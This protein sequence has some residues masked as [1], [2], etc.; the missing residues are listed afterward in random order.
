MAGYIGSKASVVSSGAERKKTFSITDTTTSLTGLSY[1]V[2]QVHVFH[3]GVRLVD[4]TDYTATDGS[5]ITLTNAAENGDEVVVI[6][7]ATFQTSDTVSASQGG[8]FNDDIEINGDLTVDTNTLYVDSTNNQVGIGTSSPS[9]PLNVQGSAGEIRLQRP[10]A[11]QADW[12]FKLPSSGGELTFYDNN[13]TTEAMRIDAGGNLLIGTTSTSIG[14][15]SSDTGTLIDDSG[16]VVVSRNGGPAIFSNR[17][18]SDGHAIEL[19]KNGTKFGE[20]GVVYSDDIYIGSNAGNTGIAIGTRVFPT[21]REGLVKD[22]LVDLG[23][24][25]ARWD[26]VY[27]TNGTIQTSDQNEKQQ[28]ASL[29]DA[30]MEAAKAISKLFK[31]FKWNDSVAEKGDDARIHT[32]VIAQ[33]VEQAMTD[34]GLNAGDYAFFISSDWVD[35]ETGEERNRKGIR[36][37]QL[38]SF[39]GA[40]TEQRLASIEARLDALETA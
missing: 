18:G 10:T 8:T 36:Y 12:S 19:R 25:S 27:A 35:E 2:S 30:E 13:N 28:I 33:E 26:D 15:S 6:S 32:G 34:A 4:G 17:L 29:T 38:L 21:Y 3:N 5:T 31:T 22:N 23:D 16:I 7:Y 40:A 1:T 14:S 37:P 11:S 24:A 20:I 9:A 39:I